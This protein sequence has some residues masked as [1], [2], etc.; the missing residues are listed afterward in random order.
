MTALEG[1]RALITGGG[2]GIGAAITAHLTAEG[3]Q[4][5]TLDVDPATRPDHVA[6]V[7]DDH[8]VGIVFDALAA[9][10]G[11]LDILVNNVGV[12]GPTG[13]V[14]DLA[15]AEFDDC[16]R[17]NVGGTFRCTHHAVPLLRTAAGG[18][19]VNLSSTAGHFGYPL[20]SPYAAAKWAI[21]GL[22]ATWAMELGPLGIRVNAV[23]PGSVDGDRMAR[24]LDGEAE[25]TGRAVD[26]IRQQYEEQV[27]MR[28]F[29]TAD[30]VAAA[31]VF[32]CGDA[33]RSI[34]GQVLSIDGNTESLR[35][36]WPH[37]PA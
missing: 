20:R 6:D 7:S 25:A 22:T 34:N 36:S 9:E 28:R 27:S 32:L 30:E 4:V 2:S 29:V 17:R 1:R 21:E 18:S 23:A 33:A 19:I 11:A 37:D 5:R 13:A 31:V 15:P 24:V 26:D 16:V 8:D 10:W 14:E 12:K 35:S 3:A